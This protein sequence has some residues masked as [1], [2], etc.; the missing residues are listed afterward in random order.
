MFEQ[1]RMMKTVRLFTIISILISILGTLGMS[2]YYANENTK[3]IAIHK[4]HGGTVRSE[5]IRNI[6]SYMFLTAIAC[7]LGVPLGLHVMKSYLADYSFMDISYALP[8]AIAVT[9]TACT[10][11]VSVLW[12]TLRAARTNPAKALKKE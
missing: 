8:T 12:Q 10:S 4:I 5:T 7:L 3:S 2:S 1:N 11:L 6:R 9:L